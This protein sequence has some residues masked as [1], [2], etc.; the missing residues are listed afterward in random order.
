MVA[1]TAASRPRLEPA[2]VELDGSFE[3]IVTVAMVRGILFLTAR[4]FEERLLPYQRLGV[5]G[6]SL[7]E[8]LAEFELA[9]INFD[10]VPCR[11]PVAH[12]TSLLP[13]P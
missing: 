13:C 2:P 3:A 9:C 5:V 1:A 10:F 4:Y 11:V 7:V 6:D 8:P 12:G